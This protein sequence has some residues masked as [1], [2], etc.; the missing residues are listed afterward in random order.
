MQKA[1]DSLAKPTFK[2]FLIGMPG[3]GKSY[4]GGHVADYFGVPFVDLDILISSGEGASVK[5]LFARYGEGG[6]RE[7]EKR[8]L[9]QIISNDTEP[10]VIACGGGTPC[11]FDNMQ[12]MK[13]AGRVVYLSAEI[14]FLMGN[15]TKEEN[16]R[17][18]LGNEDTVRHQLESL[19]LQRKD[20]Y[21]QAHYILHAKYISVAT[22]AEILRDV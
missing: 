22:F 11:F 4:W 15:L 19:Y 13:K 8:Y 14:D 7:R 21:C 1:L 2:I 5:E 17:P 9:Q 3:V 20:Y 10:S 6:F 12:L 16:T 18:L